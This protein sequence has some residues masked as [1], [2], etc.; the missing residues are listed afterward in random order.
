MTTMHGRQHSTLLR[1]DVLRLMT[2]GGAGAL[3]SACGGGAPPA[4]APTAAAVATTVP[5]AKPTTEPVMMVS[6]LTE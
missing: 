5:V 4:A 2:L 3:L 6:G 1:R